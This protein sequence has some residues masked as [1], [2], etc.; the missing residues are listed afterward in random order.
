MSKTS[1]NED[2]VRFLTGDG[3]GTLRTT[4]GLRSCGS[5]RIGMTRR[6]SLT[7]RRAEPCRAVKRSHGQGMRASAGTC[8]GAGA[9]GFREGV[10]CV[11]N[12]A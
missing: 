2:H 1:M 11:V 12:S 3:L 5:A 8:A 6:S 9:T 10:G 7:R 4:G